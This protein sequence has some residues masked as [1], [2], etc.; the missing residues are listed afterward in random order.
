MKKWIT[1]AAVAILASAG[2]ASAQS[3]RASC[4]FGNPG[5]SGK[6]VEA[7]EVPEGSTAQQACETILA[8]LNDLQCIKTYCNATVIRSGWKLESATASK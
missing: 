2:S 5:Y 6:C 3:G 4:T 7:A 8:C 1:A